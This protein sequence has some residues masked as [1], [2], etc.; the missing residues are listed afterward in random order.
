VAEKI[1]DDSK[2]PAPASV[3]FFSRLSR[4][5]PPL[6]NKRGMFAFTQK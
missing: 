5:R 6:A 3:A 2:R 1:D 4:P